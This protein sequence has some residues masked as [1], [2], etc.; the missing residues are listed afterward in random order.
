MGTLGSLSAESLSPSPL[1][2]T[3]IVSQIRPHANQNCSEAMGSAGPSPSSSSSPSSAVPRDLTIV[4]GDAPDDVPLRAHRAVLAHK[5]TVFRTPAVIGATCLIPKVPRACV[6]EALDVLYAKKPTKDK[7]E[8]VVSVF[9]KVDD[10]GP[11]PTAKAKASGW[12]MEWP[13]AATEK[14]TD[15]DDLDDDDADNDKSVKEQQDAFMATNV[16]T[17]AE[18]FVCGICSAKTKRKFHM[19]EHFRKRHVKD[20]SVYKCPGCHEFFEGIIVFRAHAL[21]AHKELKG[22]KYR[23]CRV[24]A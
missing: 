17:M 13:P 9:G 6:I 12:A 11:S 1:T 18:G 22:L 16:V 8:K 14:G 4:T 24:A 7:L 21:N 5:C 3:A 23:R 15:T 20:G 2:S 10:S 19:T